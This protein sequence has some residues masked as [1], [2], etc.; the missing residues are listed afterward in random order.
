MG[1]RLAQAGEAPPPSSSRF[2]IS[3]S[4]AGIDFVPFGLCRAGSFG[5][6]WES[7]GVTRHVGEST[8]PQIDSDRKDGRESSQ[9]A[10]SDTSADPDTSSP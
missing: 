2:P 10:P 9:R 8:A 1:P 4:S 7:V 3:A 5:I 6:V